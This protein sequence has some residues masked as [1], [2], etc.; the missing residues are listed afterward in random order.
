MSKY[1]EL[2]FYENLSTGAIGIRPKNGNLMFIGGRYYHFVEFYESQDE[3]L[4]NV[5]LT[6]TGAEP[7]INRREEPGSPE[8]VRQAYAT[9]IHD[10]NCDG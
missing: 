6:H 3:G 4:T 2:E 9:K 10:L 5:V 8:D 7:I 1:V